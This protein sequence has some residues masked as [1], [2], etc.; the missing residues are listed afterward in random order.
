MGQNVC[1]CLA[2]SDNEYIDTR[3]S[4]KQQKTCD[5]DLDLLMSESTRST[6]L[7]TPKISFNSFNK[8][9]EDIDLKFQA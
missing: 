2:K 7:G 6:D 5:Q 1:T 4:R 3:H 8:K 9:E